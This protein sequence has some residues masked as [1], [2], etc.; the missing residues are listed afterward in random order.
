MSCW[1]RRWAAL[2]MLALVGWVPVGHAEVELSAANKSVNADASV[3]SYT[4]DVTL[5]MPADAQP[6]L[7]AKAMRR[8]RGLEILRG[9]VEIKVGTLVVRTQ[10]ASVERNDKFIVVKM[11][12]AEVTKASP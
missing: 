2:A 1:M 8:E 9:E 5:K 11:D 12:A 7:R 10:Q 3:T 6:Q 4:G